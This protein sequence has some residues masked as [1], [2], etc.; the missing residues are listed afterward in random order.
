MRALWSVLIFTGI[1]FIHG[2]SW[3]DRVYEEADLPDE[4]LVVLSC[5][6]LSYCYVGS[7]RNHTFTNA[8][9]LPGARTITAFR[10]EEATGAPFAGSGIRFVMVPL[11]VGH[12]Y[13]IRN[14]KAKDKRLEYTWIE[15]MTTGTTLAGNHPPGRY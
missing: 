7:A 3:F 13:V 12:V 15:D 2:C 6:G 11:E 4:E 9:L 5:R 1:F 10:R 8:R 14:K